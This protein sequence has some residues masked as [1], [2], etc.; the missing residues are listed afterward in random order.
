MK[1]DIETIKK[2]QSE[3]KNAMSGINNT[4]E[5]INSRLDEAEDQVSILEDKVEKNN[6][7]ELQKEKRILKNEES[8]RNILDNMKYNNTHIVRIP[9]GE[10]SKPRMV[11]GSWPWIP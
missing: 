3:I 6:Q 5:G 2:D 7:A 11:A 10:E 1:K 4:L 8:L 9:E